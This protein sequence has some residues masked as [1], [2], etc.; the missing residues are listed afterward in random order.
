[1]NTIINIINYILIRLF[2][3]AIFSEFSLEYKDEKSKL[4]KKH[5]IYYCGYH[6]NYN[7]NDWR[8]NENESRKN[9]KYLKLKLT[10]FI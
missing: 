8:F 5:I 9:I 4:F 7:I 10:K 6:K 1:M 2:N 3:L